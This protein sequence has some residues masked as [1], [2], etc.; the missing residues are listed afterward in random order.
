MHAG[1]GGHDM[2]MYELEDGEQV[3]V[4]GGMPIWLFLASVVAIIVFSF[5]VVEKIG[6]VPKR[7]DGRRINLIRNRRVYRVVRSRWFQAIPQLLMVIV[8]L[9][10][11]YAG[12]FGNRIGN[13][14]PVAVWTIWWAGLVFA[15]ALFGPLFCYMCPWDGL[16]NLV[17]R[18]SLWRRTEP[19][20]LG[21][22]VP[23]VLQNMY[24]AIG[25]F[26][27]LTWAELGAGITT[28]PRGTAMMGLGMAVLAIACALIFK[29]KAF[30]S[31]LCPV[32]RISGMYANF[33]P[34]EVRARNPRTCKTCKTEDCLNGNARGY[35]C[36]TGISLK[37]INNAT[38]CTMCTEC[39]KSCDRHNVAF[40][41]RPIA[42]DLSR[43]TT[44]AD[45]AWM[46]VILLSLTLFHGFSMTTAWENH[47]PGSM[48]LIKWMGVTFG[49]ASEVNFTIGMLAVVLIPVSLYWLS[50]VVASRLVR[51][52]VSAWDLFLQYSFALLPVALFYHLAHN[53]M[54][55]F[56]EGGAIVPMLSDPLGTGADYFGTRGMHVGA[57]LSDQTLWYLQIAL[58]V[59]GHLVGIVVAHR[60]SRSMFSGPSR[61]KDATRSLVPML[62]IMVLISVAGLSLMALDMNMRVG[63][64]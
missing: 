32:G 44:R 50:C 22:D 45:E 33:S 43:P 14:T 39:V 53:A 9:F 4:M 29:K 60:L 7:D 12:L 52:T 3:M 10:L 24:P 59:F 40:N 27:I 48:S 11:L 46:C 6:S 62:V 18:L 16:A 5:V 21:F 57:L 19:L 13:I 34:V 51:S 64:M 31:H 58:I 38:M 63:R 55:L 61:T 2:A 47:A 28:D 23:R 37:V 35:A 41:I 26:V 49:T 54:H 15:V 30:C 42:D 1:H 20:T 56:A 8:L 36:P 17:S 25:L